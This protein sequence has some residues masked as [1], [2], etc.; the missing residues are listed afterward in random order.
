MVK[1]FRTPMS[2][3]YEINDHFQNFYIPLLVTSLSLINSTREA[4]LSTYRPIVN[5]TWGSLC[6]EQ[7]SYAADF[8]R[9]HH[10][11]ISHNM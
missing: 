2:I 1:D 3:L 4:D 5:V 7:N 9:L 6:A 11:Y 8:S 10:D